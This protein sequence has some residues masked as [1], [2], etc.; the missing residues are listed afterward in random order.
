MAHL[1]GWVT[2]WFACLYDWA[3]LIYKAEFGLL[4]CMTEVG[5]PVW[6][7]GLLVCMTD[8]L[9]Y[10]YVQQFVLLVPPII[11]IENTV[12][13]KVE[14]FNLSWKSHYDKIS[15]SISKS[16]GI[17]NRLK[18]LLPQELKI[19]LYNSM[20]VSHINYCILSWVMNTTE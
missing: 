1:Y 13:E 4:I 7:F 12:I 3:W 17:L 16:I 6:Q 18:R 15:Y 2:I 9:A 14:D 5:L 20:I 11:K 19:M 10:L 8:S